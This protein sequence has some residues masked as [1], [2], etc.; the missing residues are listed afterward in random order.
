MSARASRPTRR[1]AAVLGLLPL[2]VAL[3]PALPAGAAPAGGGPVGAG[4][5]GAGPAGDVRIEV[6]SG[7]GDLVTGGDAY[8]RVVLPRGASARDLR[9]D[10][11]GRDVTGQF[12][13]RPA[14][15]DGVVHGLSAGRNV[16]R[17][18]LPDGRGARITLTDAPLGGPV[19]SGPQIQPWT[20]SAGAR[21]AKCNRPPAY[22]Y[23][24]KSTAGGSLRSYDPKNPPSDVATTT[25][26]QGRTVPFIVRQETGVSVRDEYRIAVLYDP[27]KPWDPTAAQP[28]YNHKLVLTH[29]ASCD[30]AYQMGAAPDVLGDALGRGFAVASHALD[31]AGHN[32]NRVG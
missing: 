25:T 1:T 19:F 22:A 10:D 18:V 15:V 28:G 30:T 9:V 2:A 31:N 26:D 32:C 4:S 7:R 14:G 21:D 5:V 17:A 13:A 16:V 20:C 11:D 3:L 6:L 12:A 27:A 29:G 23:V 24:Y 8:L